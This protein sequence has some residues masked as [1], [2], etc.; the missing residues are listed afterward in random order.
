M[1][2]N[3][4]VSYK[5]LYPTFARTFAVDS[6]LTPSVLSLLD[7]YDWKRVAII[8]ENVPNW[9]KM[10][11]YM[12]KRLKENGITVALELLMNPSAEYR[13]KNHTD[14]YRGILRKI[15]EEARSTCNISLFP[16][17]QTVERNKIAGGDWGGNVPQSRPVHFSSRLYFSSFPLPESLEQASS[18]YTSYW[19]FYV[20]I[21][22]IMGLVQL[23]WTS[24]MR[25][26]NSPKKWLFSAPNSW[27]MGFWS[28][29][30]SILN[31]L[32]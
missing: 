28:S 5:A 13:P 21:S 26:V 31:P 10:K 32:I 14:N 15:K 18:I 25:K 2:S 20:I 3:P 1:C 17:S 16:G 12:V 24:Y 8:C 7:Y 22:E 6:A 9:I 4:D 11:D 30:C 19:T 29:N 27:D 23:F